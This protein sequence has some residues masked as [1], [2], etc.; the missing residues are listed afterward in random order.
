MSNMIRDFI[1]NGQNEN[2]VWY[3]NINQEQR[4]NDSKVFPKVTDMDQLLLVKQQEQQQL[5]IAGPADEIILHHEPDQSFISY[6]Q[7]NGI[8]IPNIIY[9][10]EKSTLQ[11]LEFK[12]PRLVAYIN[13]EDIF[14]ETKDSNISIVGTEPVLIKNIN[15][16]FYTRRLAA[17]N[18]FVV[19]QG[20]FVSNILELEE[21]YK[22]LLSQG[23]QRCVIKIPYG[24]SGKG[25]R[26]LDS[27]DEF[28][29][30]KKF[31]QRRSNTF[32]L[33]IEGWYISSE[34]INA[35]LWVGENKI[36]ILSVT[37]Q[38]IDDKGVYQG[39]CFTPN[40]EIGILEEYESEINRLGLLL[41][42]RGF[43]GICGVDSL[44]DASGNL[45]P[46]VEINARLTQ[47]TYLLPVVQK[48]KQQYLFIYSQYLKLETESSLD[49]AQ[50]S[51]KI[52]VAVNPD[53][54]NKIL[55]YTFA[56]CTIDNCSKTIYRVFVLFYGNNHN[57]V[58]LMLSQFGNV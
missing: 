49:F 53:Q 25:L 4:W 58:K 40:F 57:K 10:T 16:K 14:L 39:T 26:V 17:D 42:E 33:L 24:S 8:S 28:N 36:K 2:I 31:I 45:F 48:L 1:V 41:Q 44:I 5:F 55:I 54:D 20:T 22:D 6:L 46:I 15:N 37:K 3:F 52:H 21:A 13:S 18:G 51:E 11:Q 47:V 50:I 7:L 29:T 9:K 34:S 35:Q 19:T 12:S 38:A 23:F 27:R 43:N 30:F 56:K 32:D